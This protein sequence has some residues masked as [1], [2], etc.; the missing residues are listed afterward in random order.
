MLNSKF[1]RQVILKLA[2]PLIG[3]QILVSCMPAATTSKIS[4]S[5]STTGTTTTTTYNDPTFPLSTI[6]LQEGTTQTSTGLTL[7]YA[8]SDSFLIRG[9]A[10]S[11]YLRTIP[12]STKFCMV[13][14]Y[15]YISGSDRFL[16][17][18]AKA[19]SFTDVVNK[20]TEY[21]LYVEPA[22]DTSNQNDCLVYNLTNSL[23]ANAVNPALGFSFTQLC[24]NCSNAVTSSALKLYFINGQE[25]PT[26][27]L[28]TATLTIG[29][30]STA[31]AGGCSESTACAARGFDCCLDTQCVT[32][33]A[34][35][36]GASSLAG[37][38]AA[39]E[40][41]RLNPNRFTVYPQ[42]YFVCPSRPTSTTGG[43]AGGTTTDPAYAA[44]IRLMELNQLYQCLNKV[45]GEFS[46][47]TTK[48]TGASANIPGNFASSN[49]DDVNFS[50]LN[51]NLNTGDY[52]HNIVKIYYG[53]SVLYELNSTPLTGATF[54]SGTSNDNLTSTETVNITASLPT[55]AVDDNL[56][57]TYKIDGTCEKVGSALGKCTKTYVHGST[58][59]Y[60]TTYHS[61]ATKEFIVP[62]YG[63]FSS[64]ASIIVKIG[65]VIVPED[66][67]TWSRA[68][69]P[70]RVIFVSGYNI[71]QNQ[72]VEISY[73]VTSG[74][75]NLFQMKGAAQT[76]VN[77]MCACLSTGACNL[78]PVVDSTTS[79]ITNYECVLAPA[80]TTIPAN[81]TAYVSNKNVPHRYYDTNGVSYDSDYTS[82][83]AQ[84]L[85][86]FSY[87]SANVL[88]PNNITS[89]V[90][91]NEIYGSFGKTG[92]LIAKPA[93]LVNVKKDTSYDIY[94]ESGSF[95][96]C[97]TC[98]TDYY[99]A[100]Q[101]IFPQNFAGVGG[102]YSPNKY[103]S[104]RQNNAS[105]YR[106]DDLLYGRAC[107]VPATMIPWT[108][109]SGATAKDQRQ[110]RL[111][112]QHFL[113][114]NGYQRDWYG[115]DYGSMIGSFDGV[116]WFSIGNQRRI[117][118]ST[119]K[120][121][122][123][124]N[125]YY[126]DLAVENTF[127]V[128]V[129]ETG[130]ST[131]AMPDHDTETDGAEC[132]Q[133]HYCS[134]DNDCVRQLGYDYSCQ[135]ISG[136]STNW[137]TFDANASETVGSSPKT[138]TSI[139]G[140]TNGQAKRCVYRG[141]GAPCVATLPATT[142]TYNTSTSV[143]QIAC[144][145]NNSCS[146]ITQAKFNDRIARFATTPLAQN[147]ASASS[148][149]SDIVGLGA[150]ILGRPF[151][152]YGNRSAGSSALLSL[153]A[154]LVGSVC[155]PGKDIA[156]AATTYELNSRLP[157]VRTETSDKLFG[158]GATLS[159]SS[160]A[161]YLNACPS[162]DASGTFLHTYSLPITDA[163]LSQFSITQ[164]MSTNL[165]NLTALTSQNIY[166]S[167]SGSV[168][169]DVG[170][171]RNACLRAPG[172]S[173]FSDMEC[174]PSAF[175]SA[176]MKAATIASTILSSAEKSF[177]EEELICGNPDF[178]YVA[179]GTLSST[180]DIKKNN[181]CR[182]TGKTLSVFTQSATS[183]FKWCQ[184]NEI[185]VAGVNMAYNDKSRYSRVHT[186]YDTMSCTVGDSKPYAL[187]L[188]AT[189]STNRLTQVLAQYKTLDTINQRTCCTNNWVR[190]FSA[191]NGGGHRFARSK[192]QTIDKSIFK[193]VSWNPQNTT[194][195]TDS[196]FECNAD[197]YANSSCEVKS[198]SQTEQD[199]YLAWASSL[200]LIGIPQVAIKTNDE[201][202]KLVDDNQ[203]DVSGSK[204]PLDHSIVDIATSTEDFKDASN[205]R[206]YSAAS[207]TKFDISTS[208]LKKVFSESEFKCCIPS[209]QQVPATTS[210]EQC[211]TG[212]LANNTGV[213]RCCLPDF[214]DVTLY[215]N[216]YVSSEGRGLTDSSYDP[217]T[218]YIKDV[219][220][221]KTLATQKNLCC[222][223]TLMTGV[224][225]SKL[226]IPL[227]N[228]A[229]KPADQLSTST[230]FNYR[231]D[232]VDNNTET[233]SIGSIVDAGVRWNNHVYCVPAGFNQ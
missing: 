141:R 156:L 143:G 114:A 17:L 179:S 168:I 100:L 15:N 185:K 195:Y 144:S 118:S 230:R 127:T 81:Q 53:G 206:Y 119:N 232:A 184:S 3:C 42:Y 216:R 70:N 212:N 166:S 113:F 7:P 208:G 148:T 138:L 226:S 20:T 190:S 178:K 35:K 124:I 213:L 54:V 133:S 134:T 110:S 13:A 126:G 22:N 12:T 204:L 223:G 228:G 158:T 97:T 59:L 87:A 4:S 86:A 135:N 102:G 2:L 46:Y 174:A 74:V 69:S 29:G 61:S 145:P 25:V 211:C 214:T 205:I 201:I 92:T 95:S 219:A 83:P 85:T 103:E 130:T 89:T 117:K 161:K 62:A 197:N 19:K 91:F 152:Y 60:S 157:S 63:D 233:G 68:Q 96:T 122:L 191:E 222:S 43:S 58:D 5:N 120:L 108:H 131:I 88:K 182:E 107:F 8:F 163:A 171:Q 129:S 188:E 9:S 225:I 210:A 51:S 121:F 101:K 189:N 164:N 49:T 47:C 106:S 155:I 146:P 33:G 71:Y 66:T 55:N 79:L 56:Y 187:S 78:K 172:A 115:F 11:Q 98:G 137:P 162:T 65:G 37:F 44:A 72:T 45:D 192:F 21:Y 169:S 165:L 26:I 112:G 229:Y 181:C 6:F 41:V 1:F 227:E 48:I 200:E 153:T 116:N 159:T 151:D 14:K 24:T 109:L 28:G 64:S 105:I 93:K 139:V 80:T 231:T 104:S 31:S 218:G 142:T 23:Y 57:L 217:S 27:G 82:A 34:L 175:M 183:D 67:T 193:N 84:E 198:L 16:I 220:Q 136:L 10:L 123:A 36:P 180:Y 38:L 77:S 52:L 32:D 194:V 40:D 167:T 170:Y 149:N 76:A 30:N 177:W 132:Q 215:L 196:P 186:A 50:S 73:F 173:C 125:A 154:N 75:S 224:A 39:S 150:R 203:A 209:N 207:Y 140:G 199:L 94:V 221:V 90:G 18:A 111:A 147:L 202:F 99:N 128:T 160:S 176:K